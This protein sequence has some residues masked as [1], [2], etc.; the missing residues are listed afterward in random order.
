MVPDPSPTRATADREA[1]RRRVLTAL[2]VAL[3]AVLAAGVG[4]LLGRGDDGERRAAEPPASGPGPERRSDRAGRLAV[5]LVTRDVAAL[6]PP[7]DGPI[8]GYDVPRRLVAAIAPRHVRIDVRWDQL[9][10]AADVPLDPARVNDDGCGRE[11]TPPCGPPVSLT[12][13]FQR[14]AAQQAAHPGAFRP[15]IS[16]WGMPTWAGEPPGDGCRHERVRA[17]ARP[18]ATGREADFRAAIRTVWTA[19]R[20]AGIAAADWTPWNEPNAP[21]FLDPQR[22]ACA[23]DAE[24]RSPAPYARMAVAM[25][26]E[27]RELG[28]R[29]ADAADRHRLVLGEVAAWGA[30]TAR[31]VAADEFLRALPDDV[32]CRADVIGLHGYVD[33]RPRSGRGEPVAAALGEVERRP[34]LDD[35]AVWITETGTGAPGAGRERTGDDATQRAECR[36]MGDQLTR[37]YHH[38]RVEAAFQYSVRDDAAFPTGIVDER[39]RTAYPVADVWAAW[40][41][42]RAPDGPPPPVPSDCLESDEDRDAAAPPG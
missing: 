42:A 12:A 23:R 9:Q 36:L 28:G 24:P 38:P 4:F 35:T 14:I 39:A 27:L 8:D 5:G 13:L 11:A 34:C 1:R 33:A 18:L 7:A 41:G 32:L 29:D 37:W 21:Y 6:T 3:V 26:A 2:A 19:L 17:A 25:D 30:P 20:D 40:G 22:A 15:L 31:V 16:F 10:P